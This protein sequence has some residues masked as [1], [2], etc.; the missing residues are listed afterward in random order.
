MS[1]CIV[2]VPAANDPRVMVQERYL[3]NIAPSDY[4]KQREHKRNCTSSEP[5]GVRGGGG[6][7]GGGAR[8]KTNNPQ[9]H[10]VLRKYEHYVLGRVTTA[11]GNCSLCD[12][13][14][15]TVDK[16]PESQ[17]SPSNCQVMSDKML[18]MRISY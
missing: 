16:R 14:T 3:N 17:R 10:L 8:N 5:A 18:R 4:G 9:Q 7:G 13:S 12:V 1:A 15:A 11:A 2:D 6:G